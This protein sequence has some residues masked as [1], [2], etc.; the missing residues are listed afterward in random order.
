MG[1]V[2]LGVGGVERGGALERHQ[3][4]A[5][6][7]DVRNACDRDRPRVNYHFGRTGKHWALTGR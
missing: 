1:I 3:P 7:I 2:V 6:L 4:Q 5:R